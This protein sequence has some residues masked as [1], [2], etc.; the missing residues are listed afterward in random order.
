MIKQ[1]LKN[2]IVSAI[3]VKTAAIKMAIASAVRVKIAAAKTAS[4]DQLRHFTHGEPD[5]ITRSLSELYSSDANAA[6]A[7]LSELI[8]KGHRRPDY[9]ERREAIESYMRSKLPELDVTPAH[10]YPAYAVLD[11]DKLPEL[12]KDESSVTLP[13]DALK[14]KVTFT[15]GDSFPVLNHIVDGTK[16]RPDRRYGSEL[17]SLEDLMREIDSGSLSDKLELMTKESLRGGRDTPLDY[18]EAQIWEKPEVL[19]KLIKQT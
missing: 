16:P 9:L 10:D 6:K 4:Y 3:K 2:A 12:F 19:D 8:A 11:T 7:I 1:N 15:L 17:L 5:K 14:D 18:V 13:L